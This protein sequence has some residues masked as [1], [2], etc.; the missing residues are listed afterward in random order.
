MKIKNFSYNGFSGKLTGGVAPF[1]VFFEKWSTDPGI[2]YCKCSDGVDRLIPTFA[3]IG[4]IK[5]PTQEKTGVIFGAPSSS[6]LA[7]AHDELCKNGSLQG[8]SDEAIL[9]AADELIAILT[10]SKNR[11]GMSG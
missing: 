7:D 9:G 1:E 3:I 6:K 11:D 10:Q 8:L 4:D 5:L 2:M